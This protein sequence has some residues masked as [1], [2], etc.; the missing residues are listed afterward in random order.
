MR[1]LLLYA[2]SRSAPAALATMLGCA[3]ALWALGNQVDDPHGRAQLALLATALAAA[4]IGPGLAG[5]DINLDRTAAFA[6]PPRRAAHLIIAGCI[7]AGLLTATTL[8]G[9]PIANTA[10]IARDT[11]GLT[12]L[13]GLGA[14]LFGASRAPLLPLLWAVLAVGIPQPTQPTSQVILT[15]AMQP[16]SNSTAT[17]I[18]LTLGTSGTL[19]YA[20]RGSRR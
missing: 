13:T 1:T 6:W 16:T 9:D 20:L 7:T 14:A 11:I 15:W 17:I 8:A 5:A 18:A 2:R 19:A 4:A 3:T 10:T 12:G